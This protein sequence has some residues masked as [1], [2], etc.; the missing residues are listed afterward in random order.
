[1]TPRLRA[2]LTSLLVFAAGSAAVVAQRAGG[3]PAVPPLVRE[4]ATE[5]ISD[6]VYV[7][8]DNSVSMVPNPTMLRRARRNLMGFGSAVIAFVAAG[9]AWVVW[10]SMLARV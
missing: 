7:I 5:K 4:N 2:A 9:V 1:M 6:H 8:P 3:A 10:I